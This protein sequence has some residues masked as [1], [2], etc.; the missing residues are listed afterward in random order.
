[1]IK[2]FLAALAIGNMLLMPSADAEIKT[3][4]ASGEDF[5]INKIETQ[6]ISK[7]RAL[8]RAIKNALKQAGETFKASGLSEE[9]ISTIILNNYELN[10]LPQYEQDKNH[11]RA[12]VAIKIDDAELKNWLKRNDK[13][14][15]INQTK[16]TQKLFDANEARLDDLRG[17]VLEKNKLKVED[18]KFFRAEFKYIDNEFLSNQKVETGNKFF[19]KNRLDDALKLYTEAINLNEYNAAAYN[20]RGNIYAVKAANQKAIPAAE[21][22][23]RRAFNDFDKAIRLNGNYAEA[24]ANRGEIY[25]AGK[26]YSA[27]LKDFN[28]TIQLEPNDAQNYLNRAQCYRHTDKNLALADFNKAIELAPA[29]YVYSARGNFFEQDLND[30]SAAA[31]DYTRAI[32][33]DGNFMDY[34]RR[35]D[36]YKKSKQYGAAIDD[37]TRAIELLGQKNYL[38]AWIYRK[39]GECYQAL[40]NNSQAQADFKQ[41]EE[42]QRK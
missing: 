20:R 4:T 22:D 33:L 7:E 23:R 8:D 38:L 28:R 15:I 26:N 34:Q 6:E 13:L 31:A 39:R 10:G 42:L 35:G 24:F 19:Y 41:F 37:Y 2:K 1:M 9:E 36:V 11:W 16:E 12:T 3:F 27:A 17:R 29:A 30:Y 40:G 18:R 32:E 5:Y 25:Y 21:E 14:T